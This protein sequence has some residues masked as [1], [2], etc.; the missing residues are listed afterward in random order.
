MEHRNITGLDALHP[1]SIRQAIDP[2]AIGADKGWYDTSVSPP[3]LR[4]R[5]ATNTG[6]EDP[7]AQGSA[8]RAFAT[9][10][11][12]DAF[13]TAPVG[14][15]LAWNRQTGFIQ[16]RDAVLARWLNDGVT[17]GAGPLVRASSKGAWGD[18]AHNDR[19]ALIDMDTAAATVGRGEVNAGLYRVDANMSFSN[20]LTLT[21]N[22][23]LQPNV[24]VNIDINGEFDAS[25]QK[26]FDLSL[27]GT[28]K[29]TN[30]KT[31]TVFYL[32]HWG[33]VGDGVTDDTAAFNACL[34]AIPNNAVLRPLPRRK[35][36]CGTL[37]LSGRFQVE[38]D[39]G[40][41]AGY[42]DGVPEILYNG[43][44]GGFPFVLDRCRK[45]RVTG[46][47]ITINR[48]GH[49]AGTGFLLSG[50]GTRDYNNVDTGINLGIGSICSITYCKVFNAFNTDC[51][52]VDICRY[53][54]IQNQEYHHVEHCLLFNGDSFLRFAFI[55]VG[56]GS[57]NFTVTGVTTLTAGDVGKRIR[58]L[59]AGAVAG[60]VNRALDTTIATVTDA[61]HGTLTVAAVA[62]VVGIQSLIGENK[63]SGIRIG[64]NSNAKRQT[65]RDNQCNSWFAGINCLNGGFQAYENSLSVC[66]NAIRISG[67]AEPTFDVGTNSELC[68]RQ[69]WIDGMGGAGGMATHKTFGGRFDPEWCMDAFLAND[70]NTGPLVIEMCSFENRITD[71][72]YL[73]RAQQFWGIKVKGIIFGT[74]GDFPD[75][76]MWDPLNARTGE[77]QETYGGGPFVDW[78]SH[79][80]QMGLSVEAYQIDMAGL[81]PLVLF[82][83][84]NAG[85]VQAQAVAAKS[86]SLPWLGGAGEQVSWQGGMNELGRHPGGVP[87]YDFDSP[88]IVISTGHTLAAETVHYRVGPA[89][90]TGGSGLQ[91]DVGLRIH[92][93][94]IAGVGL[95]DAVD[96]QGPND[97]VRLNGLVKIGAK[98]AAPVDADIAN[99]QITFYLDEAGSNLK[100]RI[101]QSGGGY[102]TS[103]IAMV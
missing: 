38:I 63:G 64:P 68:L 7:Q 20:H 89:Q 28:V 61:T 101:R 67:A 66:E 81:G 40:L 84:T 83:R 52:A 95:A 103:T 56:A 75:N 58:I 8:M 22:A 71:G 98:N 26:H 37:V 27:G 48:V 1:F 99:S 21:D 29:F 24:G 32:E 15:E 74:G 80:F 43:A 79:R 70:A 5:N 12:R 25:L 62:A 3:R 13:Y 36:L 34:A 41:K 97:H 17:G 23:V 88:G 35:F 44:A 85:E 33:V 31:V 96:Q 82:R 90:L 50:Y 77:W 55:S 78:R 47:N 51:Q 54:T 76:R 4:I 72:A 57:V 69:V 73:F 46:L 93:L 49:E 102:K 65:I 59:K 100:V 86:I 10:A 6:W 18:G 87:Y 19:Q 91:K 60:G 45:C 11:A 94:L 92:P 2:G 39:S 42:D 9:T 53:A 16:R 14:E 30:N